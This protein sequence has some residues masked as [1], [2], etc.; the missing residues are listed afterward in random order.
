MNNLSDDLALARVINVPPR[1]IGAKTVEKLRAWSDGAGA[2]LGVLLGFEAMMG[3]GE[4]GAA[5]EPGD[6]DGLGASVVRDNSLPAAAEMG[7]SAKAHQAVVHFSGALRRLQRVAA[8]ESAAGVLEAVIRE[9]GYW[10]YLKNNFSAKKSAKK[11]SKAVRRAIDDRIENVQE[12][13]GI[14]R[15]AGGVDLP[16]FLENVSM[17]GY[18][19][20]GDGSVDMADIAAAVA[21]ARAGGGGVGADRVRL[22]TIHQSKGLEFDAVFLTGF[23]KSIIPLQKS[24]EGEER[25]LVY[26]AMTRAKR[27]LYITRSTWR[28]MWGKRVYMKESP[29]A[30]SLLM[31]REGLESN[32]QYHEDEW[33]EL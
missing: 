28:G 26:V 20:E 2:P 29:F 22:M 16:T 27:H 24:D 14:A 17:I 5:E 12:L 19:S 13:L 32:R 8:A 25:R 21:G 3:E 18:G 31:A 6:G 1:G 7:V 23:E 30:S 15:Q 4:D 11:Y 10:D 9:V 33:V